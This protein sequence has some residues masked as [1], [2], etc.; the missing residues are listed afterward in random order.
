M[1]DQVD[2]EMAKIQE[3][4]G[5]EIA[6]AGKAA[7]LELKR[8]AA[9]LALALAEQKVRTRMNPETQ[10]ALVRGFVQGLVTPPPGSS[11]LV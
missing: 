9:E 2:A 3:H 6:A 10:D 4:G 11:P 5:R 7:R 1:A 8:Y